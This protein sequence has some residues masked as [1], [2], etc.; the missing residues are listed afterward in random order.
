MESEVPSREAATPSREA[1]TLPG[2]PSHEAATPLINK[3]N[4]T[5]LKTVI[6]KIKAEPASLPAEAPAPPPEQIPVPGN[7]KQPGEWQQ[8]VDAINDAYLAANP[9]MTE[10]GIKVPWPALAF[11]RL[12]R[13]VKRFPEWGVK[14]WASCIS[15]R[16]ASD[17]I[18]LAEPPEVFIPYLSRYIAGPLIRNHPQEVNGYDRNISPRANRNRSALREVHAAIDRGEL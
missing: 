5:T 8:I 9:S 16:F 13:E 7:D 14:E 2:L 17:G 1:A 18:M 15:N 12:K 6:N 3:I 11:V 4:T 10:R